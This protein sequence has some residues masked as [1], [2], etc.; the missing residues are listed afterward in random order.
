MLEAM[1]KKHFE[2]LFLFLVVISAVDE[3]GF[4]FRDFI[5][6]IPN[7]GAVPNPCKPSVNWEGVGHE[8]PEGAGTRNPFGKDFKKFGQVGGG[9]NLS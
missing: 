3:T 7:G 8:N 4:A 9:K 1:E 6:K 5:G 2:K